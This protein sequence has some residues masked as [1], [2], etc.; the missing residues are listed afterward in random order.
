[1]F[2]HVWVL[3]FQDICFVEQLL[4]T[5]EDIGSTWKIEEI[6]RKKQVFHESSAKGE[7]SNM[8]VRFNK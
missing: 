3:E 6:L 7:S 2:K 8:R 5:L 4:S 1:M